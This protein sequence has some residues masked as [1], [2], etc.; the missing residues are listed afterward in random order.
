MPLLKTKMQ[1]DLSEV[2]EVD[3][4]KELFNRDISLEYITGAMYSLGES[5]SHNLNV[6]FGDSE[7]GLHGKASDKPKG[8]K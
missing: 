4:I 5:E 3:M 6:M 1:V 2:S 8:R 7:Y